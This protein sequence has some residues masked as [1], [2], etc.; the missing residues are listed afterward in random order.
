MSDSDI[1][2]GLMHVIQLKEV[3]EKII[4]KGYTLTSVKEMA[5]KVWWICGLAIFSNIYNRHCGIWPI[6]KVFKSR[7]GKEEF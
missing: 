7:C 1:V 2:K 5:A 6:T 4:G 3:P